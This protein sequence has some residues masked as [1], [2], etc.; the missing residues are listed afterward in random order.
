MIPVPRAGYTISAA[1]RQLKVSR[2]TI[3][4]WIEKGKL[5]P[6]RTPT[7]LLIPH[8]QVVNILLG[9]P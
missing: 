2:L 3:Y 4:H 7:R 5:I 8:A 9:M 1:A 6:I